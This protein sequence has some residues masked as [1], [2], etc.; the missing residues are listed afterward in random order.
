MDISG[1][2]AGRP[3]PLR[4]LVGSTAYLEHELGELLRPGEVVL[5]S[6]YPNPFR[7][8][9]HLRYGLPEE[10]HVR[11]QVFDT[12]GREV[13]LLHDGE[14]S[15]GFHEHVWDGRD[16]S[17]APVASGVYFVRLQ[18]EEATLTESIVRVR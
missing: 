8:Q 6:G 10:Q 16:R 9:V 5:D 17:G 3:L 14:A 18:A 13:A 1:L 12:L 11:L 7:T 15:T 2:K 4:L